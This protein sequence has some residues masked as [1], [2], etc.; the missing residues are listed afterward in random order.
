LGEIELGV[1]RFLAYSLDEVHQPIRSS[2]APVL[3]EAVVATFRVSNF[4]QWVAAGIFKMAQRVLF[5][6][7]AV[8]AQVLDALPAAADAFGREVLQVAELPPLQ[9]LPAS[10][11]T[12]ER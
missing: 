12:S 6:R 10:E 11:D 2:V 8:G 3:L 9:R 4:A 1:E 7:I 5:R